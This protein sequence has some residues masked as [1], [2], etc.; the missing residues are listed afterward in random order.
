MF[1]LH[2]GSGDFILGENPEAS[3]CPPL[4]PSLYIDEDPDV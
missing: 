1:D 3:L 2:Y 4:I